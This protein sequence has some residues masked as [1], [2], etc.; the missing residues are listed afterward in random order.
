MPMLHVRVITPRK[1]VMEKDISSLTVPSA[2]G[3]I[4]ILPRHVH[5]FSLLTEGIITLRG[6]GEEFLAVGGGYVETDGKNVHVLVSRAYGQ[7][8]IDARE[9]E[10][11]LEEAKKVLAETKDEGKRQEAAAI[12]R[13]SVIDIKLL[14]RRRRVSS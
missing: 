3:E 7:G 8:E 5:L 6:E 12:L 11:A 2:D 13:R 1:I 10:K 4:T 9:T 14:K